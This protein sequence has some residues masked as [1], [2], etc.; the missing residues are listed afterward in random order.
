[1]NQEIETLLFQLRERQGE[2]P[3]IRL[4]APRL[5][6]QVE[7]PQ[8]RPAAPPENLPVAPPGLLDSWRG[9]GS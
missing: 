6:R 1:M 8:N 4:V 7:M 9:Y 3:P 5:H 2:Q